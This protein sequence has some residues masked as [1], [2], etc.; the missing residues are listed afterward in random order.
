MPRHHRLRYNHIATNAKTSFRRAGRMHHLGI[1][2]EHHGKRVLAIADNATVTVIHLDTGEVI[3]TNTI[4]PDRSYWHNTQKAP[5]R[6]PEA[7]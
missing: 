7:F 6:W 3:A 4:D 1:G 2:T 5:G